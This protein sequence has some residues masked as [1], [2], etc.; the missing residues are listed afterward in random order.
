[1]TEDRKVLFWKRLEAAFFI[2]GLAASA[3]W[4]SL[5]WAYVEIRPR[6]IQIS[7]G[8]VV[9]L[10]S[11]GVVVYLTPSDKHTLQV[12]YYIGF[13][14]GIAAVVIHLVKEPFKRQRF[15]SQGL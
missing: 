5:W 11:H 14:S 13:T 2:V 6:K 10:H 15:S 9:P 8:N 1:V 3:A 4:F 12:L 7:S